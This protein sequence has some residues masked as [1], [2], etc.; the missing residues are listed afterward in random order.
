MFNIDDFVTVLLEMRISKL[1]PGNRNQC[2]DTRHV[3][4]T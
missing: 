1:E 4:S 3:N 2:V